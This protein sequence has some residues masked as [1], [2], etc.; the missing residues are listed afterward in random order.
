MSGSW[1]LVLQALTNLGLA[2]AGPGLPSGWRLQRVRDVDPP[3]FRV[4]SD[5]VLRVETR[6]GGGAGFAIYRLRSPIRPIGRSAIS[7]RWRTETPLTGAALR[8]RANDDSPVRV[9]VV[10][11]DRRMIFYTWGNAEARGEIFPSW[12]GTTRAVI[13]LRRAEDADG[14]W[15]PERRDPFAD[16]RRA[17]NRSPEAIVAVGVSADTEMLKVRAVAEVGDLSWESGP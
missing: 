8:R 17:F 7:W 9:V 1:L 6:S 14:S 13:A 5:H 2:P 10:F 15:H 4:T 3:V 11:E 12:T 16:Y